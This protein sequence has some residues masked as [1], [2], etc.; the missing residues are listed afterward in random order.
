MIYG[1]LQKLRVGY[2]RKI[3]RGGRKGRSVP[4]PQP[5]TVSGE[6]ILGLQMY[7][8]LDF[9]SLFLNPL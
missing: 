5:E 7:D 4:I 9:L 2:D 1:R 3:Q 6:M 8:K